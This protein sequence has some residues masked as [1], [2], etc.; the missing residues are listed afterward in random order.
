MKD[1]LG[2]V[3]SPD[4]GKVLR[5]VTLLGKALGRFGANTASA[6]IGKLIADYLTSG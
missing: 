2:K 5:R 1:E 4:Q 3:P 6:T